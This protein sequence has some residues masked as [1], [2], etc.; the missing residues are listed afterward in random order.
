MNIS[1]LNLQIVNVLLTHGIRRVNSYEEM[2]EYEKAYD[3]FDQIFKACDDPECYAEIIGCYED[4][5][6]ILSALMGAKEIIIRKG[7]ALRRYFKVLK[8][9]NFRWYSE[10]SYG[11]KKSSAMQVSKNTKQLISYLASLDGWDVLSVA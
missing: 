11:S 10:I 2:M 3:E 8:R 4:T 1:I 5:N 7:K 9:G 6:D